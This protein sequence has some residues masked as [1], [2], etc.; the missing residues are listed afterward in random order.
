MA[1]TIESIRARML[2]PCGN[3]GPV[4]PAWERV[5]NQECSPP[6]EVAT[7]NRPGTAAAAARV[8]I[9]GL[10]TPLPQRLRDPVQIA[11][12]QR[13]LLVRLFRAQLD[14]PAIGGM[15]LLEPP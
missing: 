12:V 8:A 7:G 11:L 3:E 15:S 2:N 13:G 5:T 9:R 14:S 10:L 6:R 1:A 4:V